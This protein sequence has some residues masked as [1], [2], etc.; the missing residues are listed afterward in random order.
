IFE[1]KEVNPVHPIYMVIGQ[2]KGNQKI[3]EKSQ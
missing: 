2:R 3:G 1:K